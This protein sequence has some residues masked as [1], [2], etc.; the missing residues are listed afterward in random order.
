M[1]G[2][3]SACGRTAYVQEHHPDGT[4]IIFDEASLQWD[5][6]N[7]W[8]EGKSFIYI[9]DRYSRKVH[10]NPDSFVVLCLECH[11]R[12]HDEGLT[13]E[14]LKARVYHWFEA[15]SMDTL[16]MLLEEPEV[17]RTFIAYLK[18]TKRQYSHPWEV[19]IVEKELERLLSI[20]E[21]SSNNAG[22]RL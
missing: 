9:P 17:L 22:N 6:E 19:S 8:R 15:S 2:V 4:K 12:L 14:E 11:A 5:L 18:K 20:H 21:L 13:V 16:R 1:R 7:A 10:V 3:C